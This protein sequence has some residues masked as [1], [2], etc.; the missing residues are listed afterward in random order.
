VLRGEYMDSSTSDPM[1]AAGPGPDEQ[2]GDRAP[3]G[4]STAGVAV[5]RFGSQLVATPSGALGAFLVTALLLAVIFSPLLP[6]PDPLQQNIAQRL[7]SPSSMHLLGTDQLGRDLLS[8]VIFGMGVAIGIAIPAVALGVFLG[9]ILGMVSGFF[10]GWLDSAVLLF[11]DTF[12]V[13]PAIVLAISLL[14]VL[15]PSRISLILA[16]AITFTPG[17]ARVVRAVVLGLREQPFILAERTLGASPFRII[18]HHLLPNVIPTV[19]VLIAMNIPS[20]I[21]LEAGL[22]FLGI[23]IQPPTPSLGGVLSQGFAVLRSSYWPVLSASAA[24]MLLTLGFTLL[25]E[26]LRDIFDPRVTNVT[27]RS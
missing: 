10:R 9:M 6:I 3:E 17:Y 16:M 26:R 20:A 15:G 4:R 8:R 27:T 18:R 13:L 22:S 11:V 21:T 24:L 5:L 12:M 19:F 7:S 1:T 14:A 25:G 23:G 2:T